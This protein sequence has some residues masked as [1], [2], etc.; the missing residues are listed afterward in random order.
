MRCSR[1][2]TAWSVLHGGSFI[3]EGDP[4]DGDPQPA[5]G[6]RSIMGIAADA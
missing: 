5:G 1:S 2:S 6:E 3:A 4:H